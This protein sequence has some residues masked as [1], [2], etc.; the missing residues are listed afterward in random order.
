MDSQ[1]I[2]F[3]IRAMLVFF[4][5]ALILSGVTAF[6]LHW[7]LKILHE[8]AGDS[9]LLGMWPAYVHEGLEYNASHYPF[10]AYGTDWLAFAHLVIATVFLGPLRDPVKNV[11][12]IQFGLLACAGVFPLALI[13][14]PLR[15]IP[16]GWTLIDCSFGFFGA[17]PLIIVLHWI[18]KLEKN[19]TLSAYPE[20]ENLRSC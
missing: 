15:G 12:V 17:F 4:I 10:M 6:P 2:L 14:G 3:K 20:N 19:S 18:R 5:F 7:E 16:W 11:W 8:A 9:S 1:S 13:C